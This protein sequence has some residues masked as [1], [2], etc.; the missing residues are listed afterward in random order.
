VIRICV[1]AAV[2]AVAGCAAEAPRLG[3]DPVGSPGEPVVY[4]IERRWHSDIG[5]PVAEIAGPLTALAR[6]WPGA[7]FL[8][9][10]FG[11]RGYVV[12]NRRSWFD[13]LMALLPGRS[14]LLTTALTSS[15]AAAFGAEHVVTLRVSAAGL[16]AIERRL[17]SEVAGPGGEAVQLADGPYPGSAFYAAKDTY[18]GLYTCNTWTTE[19]LRAGGLGLPAAGVLF[20]GQVMGPARWLAANQ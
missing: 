16:A 7:N 18:D 3:R 19:V 2:L 14:V 10:G 17:W 6:P 20:V 5:V 13:M 15:P 1:L 4:V 11:E 9:F 8:T 12:D